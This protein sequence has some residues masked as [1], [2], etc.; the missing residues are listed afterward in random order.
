MKALADFPGAVV[1]ISHDPHLVELVA[2][3][4]WLVADGAVTPFDGD[5]DDY[6]A[7]LADRARGASRTEPGGAKAG[8]RRDRADARVATAPLRARVK[9]IEAALEKFAREDALISK[10]LADP[11]TY[12]RFKPEDITW[13]NTR[14][15]RSR[16]RSR[17][18]RKNGSRYRRS[19]TPRDGGVARSAPA[20]LVRGGPHEM[21]V[22]RAAHEGGPEGAR[23]RRL[24]R[25]AVLRRCGCPLGIRPGWVDAAHHA[26]LSLITKM[27]DEARRKSQRKVV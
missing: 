7:L 3:R 4:L 23:G 9:E 2:D 27:L 13:A 10:R 19:S 21:L 22:E 25:Q 11:E 18:S 20:R 6:R 12:A 14:R 5:L 24:R 26:L 15:P 1:L 17:S 8:A 16:T